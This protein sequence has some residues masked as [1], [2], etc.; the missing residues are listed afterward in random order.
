MADGSDLLLY[1]G[2]FTD[3]LER[4]D[5]SGFAAAFT[6]DAVY[7]DVFY[8]RFEGREA[9][10]AM[11]AERWLGDGRDFRWEMRDPVFD[12]RTGYAN[13]WF[14]FT[15]TK[16]AGRRAL[17]VGASKV[18]VQGGLIRDYREWCYDG[19]ALA[20]LGVPGDVQQRRFEAQDLKFRGRADKARHLL[21]DGS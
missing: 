15:S 6:P 20:G 21:D 11:I 5:A 3:A 17:M 19:A 8:G 14:S 1:L 13:W 16:Q 12:G 4:G 2:R 7:D 18:V 9:I 10:R